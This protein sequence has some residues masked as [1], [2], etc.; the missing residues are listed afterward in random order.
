MSRYLPH[1]AL[2]FA[3]LCNAGAN[4]L[5]KYSMTRGA[6]G[7]GKLSG[8]LSPLYL[9]ALTLFGLNLLAYSW[10]L[11]SFKISAAYPVMVSGGYLIILIA[12][13]FLFAERLSVTQ[14]AG[15]GLIL[16]GIWLVV[17]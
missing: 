15:V 3:L 4:V 14:Y 9:L 8:Y 7:E 6:S 17:R 2:V 16:A 13:W 11:K 12:G 10:S 5:I 1:F